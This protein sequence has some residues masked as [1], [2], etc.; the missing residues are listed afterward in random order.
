MAPLVFLQ[1]LSLLCLSLAMD[2]H[3][4]L[5]FKKKPNARISTIL[6]FIG[7]LGLALSIFYITKIS[8]PVGLTIIYYLCSAS[9][10]ILLM[11]L[12]YLYFTPAP[13]VKK[14]QLDY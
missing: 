5:I 10:I 13:K 3:F 12:F 4:K 14:K 8:L 11:A 6:R 1:I 9:L 7:W 2:K